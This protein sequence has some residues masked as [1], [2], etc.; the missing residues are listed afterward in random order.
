MTDPRVANVDLVAAGQAPLL[1]KRY[2]EGGDPGVITA[3]LAQ[4]PEICERA[5]PF[6]RV[7]FG[8]TLISPRWKEVVVLRISGLNGCRFCTD[9]HTVGAL[10]AGLD[11]A[12]IRALRGEGPVPGSFGPTDLSVLLFAEAFDHQPEAAVTHLRPRFA[13]HEI[14]AFATLAGATVLLNGFATALGLPVGPEDRRRLAR[15][16]FAAG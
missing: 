4:V 7:A 1:V 3:A 15:A 12:E 16:G 2:F 11:P 9:T 5:V 13:D 10:D 8:T 6:L 14:V